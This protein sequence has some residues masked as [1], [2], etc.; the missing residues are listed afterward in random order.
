MG[1]PNTLCKPVGNPYLTYIHPTT[2]T[3]PSGPN[4]DEDLPSIFI[5]TS[6][7]IYCEP[8]DLWIAICNA[9]R[10]Y[11]IC[12]SE[13]ECCG[14]GYFNFTSSQPCACVRLKSN[15]TQLGRYGDYF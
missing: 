8:H 2:T 6:G 4:P 3:T 7:N 14:E 11:Y 15:N 1:R 13:S 10:P 5:P 12:L 9:S